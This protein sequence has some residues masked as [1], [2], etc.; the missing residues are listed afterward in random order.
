[1]IFDIYCQGA[2]DPTATPQLYNL[3]PGYGSTLYCM[4]PGGVQSGTAGTVAMKAV[5]VTATGEGTTAEPVPMG[6]PEGFDYTFLGA[7]FA[8]SFSIIVGLWL[9]GKSAGSIV[10]IFKPK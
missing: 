9:F 6:L 5:T 3:G 8:F 7:L 10:N 4:L 2:T 1:M